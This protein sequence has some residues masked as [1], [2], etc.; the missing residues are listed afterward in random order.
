MKCPNC[1]K[2]VDNL[3]IHNSQFHDAMEVYGTERE[4]Y[5][6]HD[7]G[8]EYDTFE[9][10]DK[11]VKE[12]HGTKATEDMPEWWND[13][14]QRAEAEKANDERIKQLKKQETGEAR[15]KKEIQKEIDHL[16]EFINVASFENPL[17]MG[18]DNDKLSALQ[19]EWA[20]AT[21]ADEDWGMIG[22]DEEPTEAPF[23]KLSPDEQQASRKDESDEMEH[24]QDKPEMSPKEWEEDLAGLKD[25][26]ATEEDDETVEFKKHM[27]DTSDLTDEEKNEIVKF[28]KHWG[29]ETDDTSEY[30]VDTDEYIKTGEPIQKIPEDK[31]ADEDAPL[32]PSEGDDFQQDME[33]PSIH[34]DEDGKVISEEQSDEEDEFLESPSDWDVEQTAQRKARKYSSGEADEDENI[35]AGCGRLEDYL[36]DD[37]LCDECEM[38]AGIDRKESERDAYE[39]DED[40][41]VKMMN[42][43]NT[44]KRM[45]KFFVGQGAESETDIKTSDD[46][47]DINTVMEPD[48]DNTDTDDTVISARNQI[49]YDTAHDSDSDTYHN[50][51]A[52]FSTESWDRKVTFNTKVQAFE[53]IGLNQGDALKLAELNWREL[54]IEV[55]GALNEFADNEKE[56]K[57][58][59]IQDA[60]NDEGAGGGADQPDTT[61]DDLDEIDYNIIGD[62]PVAVEKYEC[63]HCNSGFRSNE[64][65]MIHYNDL[66]VPAREFMLDV[67]NTCT[68]CG[69]EI[70]AN[71]SMGEHLAYEHGISLDVKLEN[72]QVED[73]FEG[74]QGSGP[75]RS[76]TPEPEARGRLDIDPD[77][78]P[79]APDPDPIGDPSSVKLTEVKKKIKGTEVKANEDDIEFRDPAGV[80]V[81]PFCDYNPTSEED[82]QSHMEA[83]HKWAGGLGQ[84]SVEESYAKED[85]GYANFGDKP[86][87][88]SWSVLTVGSDLWY[89]NSEQEARDYVKNFPD[90]TYQINPPKSGES[91][92]PHVYKAT[93]AVSYEEEDDIDLNTPE[94]RD[95]IND[96]NKPYDLVPR[97]KEPWE[98]EREGDPSI[99]EADF[100]EEEHPREESGKFTSGGG[101]ATKQKEKPKLSKNFNKAKDKILKHMGEPKDTYDRNKYNMVKNLDGYP[102]HSSQLRSVGVRYKA[103]IMKAHL[104]DVYPESKWSVRTEYYS[105]GSSINAGW[106]GGGPYPY[107]ASSIKELYSDSGATD[108]MTDYFDVDNY[109]DLYDHRKDKP[110]F[111]HGQHIYKDR[112]E[113]FSDWARIHLDKK[114]EYE[115]SNTWSKKIAEDFT[116]GDVTGYQGISDETMSGLNELYNQ[117]QDQEKKEG[118]GAEPKEVPKA[119]TPASYMKPTSQQRA[120]EPSEF[121]IDPETGEDLPVSAYN[122]NA[123]KYRKPDPED[124]EK[125]VTKAYG[126]MKGQKGQTDEQP[127]QKGGE[128]YAKEDLNSELNIDNKCGMC[129]KTFDTRQDLEDHAYGLGPHN[130]TTIGETEE[131]DK[132]P[133]CDNV[134]EY[135]QDR[136]EHM[137]FVHGESYAKEDYIPAP[138]DKHFDWVAS[139]D[140]DDYVCK[141]CGEMMMNRDGTNALHTAPVSEIIE[142]VK[143]HL[144]THGITES[145]AKEVEHEKCPHCN[146]ETSWKEGDEWQKEDAK[147]EMNNHIATHGTTEAESRANEF[148]PERQGKRV[149]LLTGDY[150][151]KT[152]TIGAVSIFGDDFHVRVD[153]VHN[154][155]EMGIPTSPRDV[156]FLGGE[157]HTGAHTKVY[158]A[159][160]DDP[161]VETPWA[162]ANY[163][164]HGQ[165]GRAKKLESY[166]EEGFVTEDDPDFENDPDYQGFVDG[167]KKESSQYTQQG[168]AKAMADPDDDALEVK[169][170]EDEEKWECLDCDQKF[171][172]AGKHQDETGHHNITKYRG[173]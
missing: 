61:I 142:V 128:S 131:D 139:M 73:G 85:G 82:Y 114:G 103:P 78:N 20:N 121:P 138:Y 154:E 156:E 3:E 116:K 2:D 74:G 165:K 36:S 161:D 102:Q 31:R 59:D 134:D 14:E 126:L 15:T 135:Q 42:K 72:G 32:E 12:D 167:E 170:N 173:D 145:Y 62:N 93:E 104:Q 150:A 98:E 84:S 75:Q 113:R 151:G 48:V 119:T 169:A 63:E 168:I 70:P 101:G 13:P 100:K 79:Y 1:G 166:T 118:G 109:V 53:G 149:K 45:N 148:E 89:F 133:I 66:H 69:Q 110:E 11:H 140:Q 25:E 164:V 87:E 86:N 35:C 106:T 94:G 8:N 172:D 107:G 120:D 19:V 28:K 143:Q 155:H 64:A 29:D 10:Y 123:A 132:C 90:G 16:Q 81:C 147:T 39:V 58:I 71:V 137:M 91:W 99:G 80:P 146:F 92:K 144:S 162:L 23:D 105:G 40:E 111:D 57:R 76:Y 46:G 112:A 33:D 49:A 38:E 153:G 157:A 5:I 4:N 136:S 24:H 52:A 108:L 115:A 67:P 43:P 127:W 130:R 37:D 171:N 129:G 55:R 6:C 158:D 30:E 159:V 18:A 9:A 77:Y 60:F 68:Y 17:N 50:D 27:G 51:V 83:N 95:V 122:P 65:L 96:L 7:C 97:I 47:T 44:R 54:S 56:E 125:D 117:F 22:S 141:H 152:G 160:K 124:T 88:N 26:Y 34:Y 21:E 41:Y 163:V